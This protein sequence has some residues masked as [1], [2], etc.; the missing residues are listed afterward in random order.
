MKKLLPFLLSAILVLSLTG[1]SGKLPSPNLSFL[2]PATTAPAPLPTVRVT[3][4]EG[5]GV[6]EIAQKLEENGVCSSEEF[7]QLITDSD[8]LATLEYSVLDGVAE[9]ESLAFKLEGF[10]FPDTYE[11]YEGESAEKALNRFLKNTESKFTAEMKQRAAELGMSITDVLTLASIIQEEASNPAEMPMV[12]SVFHNRLNSSS[13]PRLES[14]VTR[15]YVRLTLNGSTYLAD[16][17][18]DY[19]LLYD[20]YECKGLPAG[21]ICNPG[22]NAINAALYPEESEYYFFFTDAEGKYYYNTDYKTHQYQYDTLVR[23]K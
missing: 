20:T 2:K 8:Y 22:L 11:F 1:C 23:Y 4:P 19:S 14:D 18:T 17:T 6:I 3:F 21:P 12:S 13:Y 10:V 7:M 15:N 9:N 16:S 5:W